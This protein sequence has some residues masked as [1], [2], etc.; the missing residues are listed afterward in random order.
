M[1]RN[2][3]NMNI[4]RRKT[5]GRISNKIMM[6]IKTMQKKWYVDQER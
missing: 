6:I 2:G 1:R 5:I 3:E 4:E